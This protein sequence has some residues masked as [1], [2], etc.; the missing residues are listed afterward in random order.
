MY[1]VTTQKAM[2]PAIQSNLRTSPGVQLSDIHL[3]PREGLAFLSQLSEQ[4]SEPMH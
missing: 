3:F 4:L 2:I 1:A